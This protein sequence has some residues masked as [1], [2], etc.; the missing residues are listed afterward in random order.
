[1]PLDYPYRMLLVR[2]YEAGVDMRSGITNYEL[3]CDGGKFKPFD[4][5]VRY[6]VNRMTEF[7]KPTFKSGY[8]NADDADVYQTW[9]GIDVGQAIHDHSGGTIISA[10]SFWPGQFTVQAKTHAGASAS[11]KP[12]HWTCDGWAPHNLLPIPVGRLNMMDEWFDPRVYRSIRLHLTQ[13]NAGAEVNVGL[14]QL[15]MY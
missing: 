2:V 6:L 4:C 7:F 11:N 5:H 14:Q 15:R 13:G 10:S 1:M 3:N 9:I 12:I 8:D